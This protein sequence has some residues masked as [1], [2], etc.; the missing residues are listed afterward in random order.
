MTEMRIFATMNYRLNKTTVMNNRKKIIILYWSLPIIYL[1]WELFFTEFPLVRDVFPDYILGAI[2]DPPQSIARTLAHKL[3]PFVIVLY[4]IG[5]YLFLTICYVIRNKRW[6]LLILVIVPIVARIA[7]DYVLYLPFANITERTS[8]MH[9]VC[10]FWF[11]TS[12][13]A[14]CPFYVSVWYVLHRMKYR[15]NA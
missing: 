4:T 3:L 10:I 5:K 6:V 11:I 1:L 14:Y 12:I 9:R 13:I 15:K 8:E 2:V 7:I